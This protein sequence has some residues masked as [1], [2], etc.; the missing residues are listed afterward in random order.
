MREPPVPLGAMRHPSAGHDPRPRAP[1]GAP[2]RRG[3]ALLVSLLAVLLLA[4]LA[5]GAMHLERGDFQR[6]RDEGVMRQASNAA[7]AGAYDLLRRWPLLPHEGLP[8]GAVLGP[9][10][11]LLAGAT[12]VTRAMRTSRTHWWVVSDGSAGDSL[13]NTLARRSVAVALRLAIPDVAANAALVVR[14]SL[15]LGGSARVVGTDTTLAGWGAWCSAGA[16]AAGVAMPDTSRLCDGMCGG[17]ST[18]GRIHGLPSLL[19]DSSAGNPARYRVFGGEDWAS[20]TRHATLVLPPG[21]VITPTPVLANGA[22]DR[23]HVDNWGDPGGSGAC[24]TYAPL[25]WATGDVEVRGGV[26]QGVLLVDGDL[27]LS[28][29][30]AFAGVVI[31]RD[32]ILAVGVGGTI[33]GVALAADAGVASGDH[34]RL[35]GG[36]LVQRSTCAAD[37]ATEWSARLVPV[38]DRSWSALR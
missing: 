35:E 12:A 11:L 17:G 2:L 4:V 21:S 5:A 34:T 3:V 6:A 7:D 29:G 32:D 27:T 22:C 14:D 15:T 19:A 18:S 26:G 24:A 1:V 31:A 30:A 20:L 16:T 9:D 8:V 25:I 36:T 37:L 10:T 23:M 33:L 38:R 28:A 13:A